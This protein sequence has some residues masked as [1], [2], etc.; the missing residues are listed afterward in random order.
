[1]QNSQI[2]GINN[3]LMLRKFSNKNQIIMSTR[4]FNQEIADAIN[5]IVKRNL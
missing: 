4:W 1:M 5:L 2:L 3:Y